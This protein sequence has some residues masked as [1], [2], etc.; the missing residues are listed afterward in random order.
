MDTTVLPRQGVD[1]TGSEAILLYRHA[2]LHRADAAGGSA[3]TISGT[4]HD[5]KTDRTE[6]LSPGLVPSGVV[7]SDADLTDLVRHVLRRKVDGGDLIRPAVRAGWLILEGEV[8]TSAQKR[9]AEDAV[10]Q[11]KG[12][13]GISNNI[14]LINVV[15]V[16]RINDSIDRQFVFNARRSAHGIIVSAQDRR[17]ILSGHVPSAFERDEAE[18]VAWRVPGVL[19]VVNRIRVDADNT[20]GS[21]GIK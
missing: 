10:R 11:I 5:V 13:R 17:I 21:R 19:S 20:S 15:L 9:S 8:E 1:L 14:M 18:S 12:I 4:A 2:D 3:A 7:P 16:Q 6:G